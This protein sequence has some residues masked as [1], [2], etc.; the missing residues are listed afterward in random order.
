MLPARYSPFI[1]RTLTFVV[2]VGAGASVAYWG[3][4]LGTP[5]PQGV[6][7]PVAAGQALQ[8]DPNLVAKALGAIKFEAS[9]AQQAPVSSRFVLQ[10]VVSDARRHG[11]ALIS[12]DGKPARPVRVGGKVEEGLV[13]QTVES[14]RA[15][16]GAAL[17]V[18]AQFTLE[19]PALK[20]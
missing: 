19:L 7:A 13:L 8:A 3:L 2:W 16:L 17:D 20:K 14:R 1:A 6:V 11:V 18:P 15:S 12:V 5:S 4:K 9:A 10:G